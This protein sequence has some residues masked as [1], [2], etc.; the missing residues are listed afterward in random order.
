MV[1]RSSYHLLCFQS[2]L[3]PSFPIF[4]SREIHRNRAQ[5]AYQV[6]GKRRR[7]RAH[8]A[9]QFIMG[10]EH[11]GPFII[12]KSYILKPEDSKTILGK[13][14]QNRNL[15]VF[16]AFLFGITLPADFLVESV[17][18]VSLRSDSFELFLPFY[19]FFSF[20][21]YTHKGGFTVSLVEPQQWESL[22]FRSLF[23]Y[24]F[25]SPLA[26]SPSEIPSLAPV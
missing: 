11:L 8:L 9:G 10:F 3:S 23:S 26:I 6:A 25:C 24:S 15:A 1:H 19:S 18:G 20:T 14:G 2:P 16:S 7:I 4:P 13:V 22:D 17:N 5:N 12:I 21:L